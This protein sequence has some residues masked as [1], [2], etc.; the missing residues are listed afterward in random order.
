MPPKR[1]ATSDASLDD[2]T[3]S[4][5]SKTNAERKAEAHAK[6]L[7]YKAKLDAKKHKSPAAAASATTSTASLKKSTATTKTAAAK[8]TR[9]STG[10]DTESLSSRSS[11]GSSRST[12]RRRGRSSAANAAI[13]EFTFRPPEPIAEEI[14]IV[15]AK[16]TTTTKTGPNGT[17]VRDVEYVTKSVEDTKMTTLFEFSAGKQSAT[18]EEY[19]VKSPEVKTASTKKSKKELL[20]R[21][22]AYGESLNKKKNNS[23]PSAAPSMPAEPH[24]SVAADR[25]SPKIS[26][27]SSPAAAAAAASIPAEPP[28]QTKL[29]APPAAVANIF[30]PTRKH[31]A[32]RPKAGATFN[33]KDPFPTNE[34]K[35]PTAAYCGCGPTPSLGNNNNSNGNNGMNRK[36][37]AVDPPYHGQKHNLDPLGDLNS[38]KRQSVDP[39]GVSAPT[40]QLDND[41]ATA[42]KAS[43]ANA[44]ALVSSVSDSNRKRR[45]ALGIKSAQMENVAVQMLRVPTEDIVNT[46]K[47]PSEEGAPQERLE[48]PKQPLIKDDGMEDAANIEVNEERNNDGEELEETSFAKRMG[49]RIMSVLFVG[50]MA[51]MAYG[52]FYLATN[53]VIT[54]GD[55]S[56]STGILNQSKS[57]EEVAQ[58]NNCFIDHPADFFVPGE[59]SSVDFNCAG[60]FVPCPQWGRCHGGVLQD[61]NHAGN[62]L[63]G[64]RK[65]LAGASRFTPNSKGSACVPTE[66]ATDFLDFAKEV[67]MSMT[68]SQH[69]NIWDKLGKADVIES[70]DEQS[71]P[72]FRIEKVVYAMK[73]LA[74]SRNV[75]FSIEAWTEF[76]MWL[77]P[78]DPSSLTYGSFSAN[79]EIIID[80]VGLSN[81]VSLDSLPFPLSCYIRS[82]SWDLFTLLFSVVGYLARSGLRNLYNHP[83]SSVV[84]LV[85]F[86]ITKLYLQRKRRLNQIYELF[87]HVLE[88]TYDRLA[89]LD[90]NEGYAALLLRD[91]IGRDMYPTDL[92]KRAFLYNDVWPR[93]IAEIHSDNRVRKF[94]KEANGKNLEHWD[95][96]KQS[97]QGRRLRKSLGSTNKINGGETEEAT[98]SRDP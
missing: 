10:S 94:R 80:A 6:A 13:G 89:E 61:C 68:V 3:P 95:L 18:A 16:T 65:E 33:P 85:L 48:S 66:V 51:Q 96:H 63:S 72:L 82:I 9:K 25:K 38:N 44:H 49:K 71:Y 75:T 47:E 34:Y 40:P 21:A 29:A 12:T 76:L 1:K 36:L 2:E 8:R 7:A 46:G 87:P 35:L 41:N 54:P 98:A 78:V 57:S 81:G 24:A 62:E 43:I 30:S 86:Y 93:I 77:E 42:V 55:E 31:V 45:A 4:K 52:A 83:I 15:E 74:D 88:T 27:L 90:N 11:V 91:D 39:D 26:S 73:T 19:N 60:K 70:S 53:H 97:K 32:H 58:R 17:P 22:R 23:S 64:A 56:N 59:S 5:K 92:A 28:A 14:E 69:C 50:M 79:E 67:L 37:P 20:E 84:A